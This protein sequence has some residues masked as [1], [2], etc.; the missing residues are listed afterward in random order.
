M[1]AFIGI[2][3]KDYAVIG[4]DTLST[5]PLKPGE[6]ELEPRSYTCKT[7]LLPHF[8][9]AFSVTGILQLALSFHSFMV[10]SALGIDIDSII[11]IDLIHFKQK[12][13][14]NYTQF[15]SGTIYLVGFSYS[16]KCFKSFKLVVEN[17]NELFWHKFPDNSFIAKPLVEDWESKL[18]QSGES[19]NYSNIIVKLMQ[20]QKKED[21]QKS[22]SE[23]VGIGGEVLITQLHYNE[24]TNLVTMVTTIPFEFDDF[25]AKGERIMLNSITR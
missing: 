24:E 17:D 14:T 4:S 12:I 18:S 23:Q 5:Y 2:I 15:P 8:K 6:K 16:A 11:N 22:V 20:I 3:E 1:T 10:E 25:D 13:N 7:F 9:S 19:S 21:E